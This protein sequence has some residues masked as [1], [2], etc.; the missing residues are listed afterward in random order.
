MPET[1]ERFDR[2]PAYVRG[3]HLAES[4]DLPPGI[5]ARPYRGADDLADML[6]SL[7][8]YRAIHR[9]DEFPTLEQLRNSYSHLTD[10]DPGLDIAVF[11][12]DNGDPVGYARASHEDAETGVRDCI[13]FAPIRPAHLTRALFDAIV[14]GMEQHMAARAG[15]APSARYRAY[16][17]HPG[18]GEAPVGEAAWLESLGYVVTEWG[19]SLLRPHLDD[20]ADPA[21]LALPDGVEVR[22]V[23]PDQVRSIW[24]EHWEAFRGEW[25]F[26]EAT[27]DDIDEHVKDPILSD[28]SLWKVAWA[29]DQVVGQVKSFINHE[30]NEERGYLRGYAE[31]I[32]THRDWRN[33]GIAS[34]LLAMSLHELRDRGMTEAML[35]VD[36][37]NPGGVLHV[38]TRLGFAVRKYDAVYTKPISR[39]IS[40]PITG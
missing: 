32:S 25:D 9:D 37:N 40:R 7:R 1:H 36:T 5:V 20:I 16:S 27:D 33:R 38:Y 28:I 19:A 10:C 3:M 8:A 14:P 11:E 12:T 24:E 35:G 6:E 4:F 13:V 2:A 39:P 34:A 30:E 31:Y 21:E 23:T 26:K 17:L 29:G 15:A 22:P 18:P